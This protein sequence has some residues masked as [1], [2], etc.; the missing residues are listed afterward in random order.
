MEYDYDLLIENLKS[1]RYDET[2]EESILSEGFDNSDYPD[3]LRYAL[4]SMIEIDISYAYKVYQKS[5][6]IHAKIHREL[7]KRK[8][9]VEY[10]Y[11]GALKT[12][13]NIR[14]YGDVEIIVLKKNPSGKPHKDIHKLGNELM[15]ILSGDPDFKSVDFSDKS[16]IKITTLKPACRISV[17]PSIWVNTPD[18]LKTKNEIHRGITEF[19][20]V[21]KRVKTYFPFLNIARVNAKDQQVDGNLKTY[22]R[23]LMTLKEDSEDTI[24]V[25][26]DEMK[27]FLYAILEDDFKVDKKRILSILPVVERHLN[28][29]ITDDIFFKSLIAPSKMEQVFASGSEKRG[30][31]VKIH[32]S[33]KVLIDDIARALAERNLTL[34]D[35]FE[36]K[37]L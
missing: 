12:L 30:E 25:R 4:E 7:V 16:R 24:Q 32:Q 28:R 5:R 15:D 3:C 11:Q 1:R 8:I 29:V 17:L 21:N 2:L 27:N 33:L 36:Y 14:L 6:R 35:K 10:R 26:E 22:A 23:L 20:F 18:F 31:L 9:G 13:T 37:G 19:D 34:E